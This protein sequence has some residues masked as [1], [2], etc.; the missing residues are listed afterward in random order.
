MNRFSKAE[1]LSGEP[2]ISDLV[3]NGNFFASA[4]LHIKY[5][6]TTPVSGSFLRVAFS[7]PKRLFKKA[8]QRN[9]LKRRMR[10]AYRKDKD[11]LV[12]LLQEK[13]K[14]LDIF[15]LYSEKEIREFSVIESA[16][17]RCL[18]KVSQI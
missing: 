5:K 1:R 14:G 6:E 7:V 16:M 15:I 3:R 8:T 18:K 17:K 10:E 2:V 9:L 11:E 4:P 13:R 12:Q